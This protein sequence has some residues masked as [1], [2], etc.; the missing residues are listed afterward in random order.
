MLYIHS[1]LHTYIITLYIK[2]IIIIITLLMYYT[3]IIYIINIV[4]YMCPGGS[5]SVANPVVL[6]N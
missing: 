3:H 6:T 4:Y 2:H 1:L 5:L